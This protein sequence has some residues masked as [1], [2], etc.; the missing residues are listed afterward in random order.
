MRYTTRN[1]LAISPEKQKPACTIPFNRSELQPG[2][3]IC[4]QSLLCSTWARGFSQRRGATHAVQDSVLMGTVEGNDLAA[5]RCPPVTD[6]HYYHVPAVL[7]RSRER[8]WACS[9]VDSQTHGTQFLPTTVSS[10][11]TVLLAHGMC[12]MRTTQ[13][14]KCLLFWYKVY[15]HHTV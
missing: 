2:R 5:S 10:W 1:L 8:Q 12:I 3:A 7:A 14:K 15:C 9:C 4:K 11:C 6:R 13:N